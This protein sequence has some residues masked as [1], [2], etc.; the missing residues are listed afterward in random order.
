V[1]DPVT[2]QVFTLRRGSAPLLISIPHAGT[3]IPAAIAAS[4]TPIAREVD[5]TDWHLERLYA[6]AE[7]MGASILVPA[8]SRY[9][10]DLNRPPDGA[11]L[12]PGRDTTGLCPVD[13]FNSE[14]LYL[15]G[16]APSELQIAERRETYWRPYHDALAG[17][18]ARLKA[19]HGKALLWEAH[20]IRSHVPRFFDGKLTDFNFGT[21][22]GESAAAGLAEKLE[23]MVVKQGAYTAVANGR[24][25]GGYITRHYGAPQDGIHAVQ[26]E[27]S[28]V[29]YMEES[30]PY[31]YDEARA[32]RVTPLMRDLVQC[33]LGTVR[34][35]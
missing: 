13:T 1:T 28:Q 6:F 12:Y 16:A 15:T 31:A 8:N 17:E 21:A 24:F 7:E 5:D 26:L 10:I 23:A 32:A 27:L 34:L 4:M 30:R 19:V 33:A 2:D 3:Q 9:V 14:P 25:K 18:L 22:S 20:S 11:N 35:A 29:T